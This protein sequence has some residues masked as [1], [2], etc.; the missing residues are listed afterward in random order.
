[1]DA[2]DVG[3]ILVIQNLHPGFL[4][5]RPSSRLRDFTGNLRGPDFHTSR[6]DHTALPGSTKGPCA[7]QVS[8]MYLYPL[9]KDYTRVIRNRWRLTCLNQTT[10]LSQWA[11]AEKSES[12]AEHVTLRRWPTRRGRADLLG[13]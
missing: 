7:V 9:T 10:R 1:M 13:S 4:V 2:T 5:D 6:S 12:G 3:A 8:K 11:L